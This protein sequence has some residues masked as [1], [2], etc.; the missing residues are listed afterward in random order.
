MCRGCRKAVKTGYQVLCPLRC[1]YV[2]WLQEGC[3][4]RLSGSVSI[5]EFVCAV[6]AGRLSRPVI[7]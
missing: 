6:A 3:Q 5:E 4:D 2:P 7:R 1:S